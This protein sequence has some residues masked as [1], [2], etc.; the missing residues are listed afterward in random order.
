MIQSRIY[1]VCDDEGKE[2]KLSIL[3]PHKIKQT[4]KLKDKLYFMTS[5]STGNL[6]DL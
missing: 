6:G 2:L 1:T 5:P 3:F 4:N